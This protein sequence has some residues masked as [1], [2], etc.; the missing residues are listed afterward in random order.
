MSDPFGVYVHFPFCLARCGYCDFASTAIARAAIPQR[1]YT[2]AVLAELAG[3][4]G[5][6]QGGRLR[7]IH[8]GG[9]TPSLW[10]PAE[11]SRLTAALRAAFDL[12]PRLEITVEVNPGTVGEDTFA[13]LL[14]AGVTRLSLGVQSLDDAELRRLGRI[15]SADDARRAVR[16][17]R[18]AGA[19]DLG[20][21]LIFGLPGQSLEQHLE[22]LERLLELGLDH[23]STYALSLSPTAPLTR[24][25]LT[26]AEGEL[27]AE[28]MEAGRERLAAAGIEQY[29]VSNFARAGHRSRHHE[30]VWAGWPYLGLGA[31]ACSLWVDGAR[32]LRVVNP[33]LAAY[34][35]APLGELADP[36]AGGVG[37]AGVTGATLEV[38]A[39]PAS[40]HEVIF[41]GLRTSRGLDRLRYAGRFGEVAL[42]ELDRAA[43]PLEAAALL[44]RDGAHLAPTARGIWLADE[45]ALRLMC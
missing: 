3:R 36:G 33:P 19:G 15:H 7:A 43:A 12:E 39:P 21:D 16:D 26:P 29:E 44:A 17:A 35:Q 22:Q 20:C 9:G 41:L 13:R 28:M 38:V 32:S 30:L 23:V 24:A 4:A 5:L 25:G 14:D 8:V 37:L 45:L 27:Q 6:Y 34:L 40:R 42:E 10:E 31:S 1:A 2:D 18:A 11:L